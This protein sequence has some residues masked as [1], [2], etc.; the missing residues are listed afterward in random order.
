M[1]PTTVTAITAAPTDEKH[2]L[3]RYFW[4]GNT[5]GYYFGS[6]G[7]RQ[8][9][10]D[11]TVGDLDPFED[12]QKDGILSNV[13]N[14][15]KPFVI[16]FRELTTAEPCIV[17]AASDGC[18]SSFLSPLE[19]EEK[20]L[21]TLMQANTPVEWEHLLDGAIGRIAGDDYT[22]QI[23]V[24][25]FQTFEAIKMAFTP[26]WKAFCEH[27]QQRLEACRNLS[28]EDPNLKIVLQNLWNEYK[29]DFLREVD[30]W[31]VKQ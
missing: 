29:A 1:L 21:N 23:A 14:A 8:I 19:L 3:L 28:A 15:T 12:L 6:T 4:A 25:G 16:H 30:K 22:M 26:R 27:Y 2:I 24:L 20:L 11:D 10:W 5:R 31:R 17:F 9:T 18:F 7:L 13:A